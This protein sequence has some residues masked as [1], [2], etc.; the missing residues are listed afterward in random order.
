MNQSVTIDAPFATAEMTAKA[1]GVSRVRTK[2]LV[3]LLDSTQK[4]TVRFKS[5]GKAPS[6]KT[7]VA[8]RAL[9]SRKRRTRAKG[10]KTGR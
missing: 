1:L 4:V 5:N 6:L 7:R 3:K 9:A 8:K 10:A 2:R